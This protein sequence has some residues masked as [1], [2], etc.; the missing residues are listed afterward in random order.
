[1]H[2]K[3]HGSCLCGQVQFELEGAFDVFY[4]CHC[5]YCQKDTGSAHSANLFSKTVTLTWQQGRQAV[6]TYR[7]PNTQ[8]IKSFCKHCGSAVPTQLDDSG[9]VMV[10]AGCLDSPLNLTPDAK[11]FMDSQADWSKNLNDVAC[12]KK[13]PT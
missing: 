2:Q 11:I 9:S 7:H 1:M 13:L 5:Q 4:L 3:F 6:K 12:F 8:H 10:P